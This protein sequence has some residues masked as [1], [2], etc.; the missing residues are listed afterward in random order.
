MTLPLA[1]RTI[2]LF[3]SC[4]TTSGVDR[5]TI[6]HIDRRVVGSEAG[7]QGELYLTHQFNGLEVEVAKAREV[8]RNL[9]IIWGR[10]VHVQARIDDD[11]FLFSCEDPE[12]E[13]IKK[14]KIGEGT[15]RPA[16]VMTASATVRRV[17]NMTA[18]VVADA[19]GAAVT[20]S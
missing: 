15:A 3:P 20:A 17:V 19:A 1:A 9:R 14:E 6:E 18:L 16:H 11:H 10:P 2:C 8:L 13:D 5:L 4:S 12:A 7:R